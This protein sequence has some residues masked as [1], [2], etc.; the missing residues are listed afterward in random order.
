MVR[1]PRVAYVSG[2]ELHLFSIIIIIPYIGHLFK[3]FKIELKIILIY[4][5]IFITYYKS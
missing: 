1:L 5:I 2:G 4:Y 3:Y